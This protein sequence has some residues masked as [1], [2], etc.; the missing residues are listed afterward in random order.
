[1]NH[2]TRL[3]M[4]ALVKLLVLRHILNAQKSTSYTILCLNGLQFVAG[5]GTAER[6]ERIFFHTYEFIWKEHIIRTYHLPSHV[7]F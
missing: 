7:Y 6:R 2:A 4:I 1:M 3:L 5:R